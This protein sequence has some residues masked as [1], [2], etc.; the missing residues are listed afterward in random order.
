MRSLALFM[1]FAIG[2]SAAAAD[3]ICIG[4]RCPIRTI[5]TAP[6]RAVRPARTVVVE[7][8]SVPVAVTSGPRGV[9]ISAQEHADALAASGGFHHCHNYGGGYEGLGFSTSSDPQDAVRR[10]C[11]WGQRRPREIATAWCPK[12]RGFVA[13]VRYE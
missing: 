11:F 8:S 6:V 1:V 4:G 7:P 3:T 13:V 10:C 9:V 5:V 2:S 12:R